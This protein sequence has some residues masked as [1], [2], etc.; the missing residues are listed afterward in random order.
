MISRTR[1]EGELDD[2]LTFVN[3]VLTFCLY[4]PSSKDSLLKLEDFPQAKVEKFGPTFIKILKDYCQEKDI[5]MDDFP[6][7]KLTKVILN[8][9]LW[10]FF[11]LFH[12]VIII[13]LLFT[14]VRL[15]TDKLLNTW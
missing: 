1:S 13:K 12:N 15:V 4:R 11:F 5:K 10:L 6:D 3:K 7:I 9:S 2:R 8:S 14:I